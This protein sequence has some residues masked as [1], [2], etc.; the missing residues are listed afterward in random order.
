MLVR[1][2]L[3]NG[4]SDLLHDDIHVFVRDGSVFVF[5]LDYY[6]NDENGLYDF[7]RI[8]AVWGDFGIGA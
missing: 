2:V 1:D 6:Q 5:P 3:E 4:V 8:C 7:I